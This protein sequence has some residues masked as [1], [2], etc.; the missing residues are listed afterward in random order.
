MLDNFIPDYNAHVIDLL[1]AQSAVM[2]GKTNMDEFG[3]G[4]SSTT[5]FYGSVKNPLNP[6]YTAG[7]SSSGS[8]AAW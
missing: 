1:N 2:L 7:G 8:A 4:N 5:S 6:L 3:M